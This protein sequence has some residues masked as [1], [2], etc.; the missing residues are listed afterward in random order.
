MFEKAR[1]TFPV[2]VISDNVFGARRADSTDTRGAVVTTRS[3]RA[4]TRDAVRDNATYTP[5][6]SNTPTIER[7]LIVRRGFADWRDRA[8]KPLLTRDTCVNRISIEVS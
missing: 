1:D 8:P 6:K 7:M 4:D 3:V 5:A 2:R